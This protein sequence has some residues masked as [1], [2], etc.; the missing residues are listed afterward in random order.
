[1]MSEPVKMPVS[2]FLRRDYLH[3][4]FYIKF[5]VFVSL[6]P[7]I[8]Y[9]IPHSHQLQIQN[10]QKKEKKNTSQMR[11]RSVFKMRTSI[12]NTATTEQMGCIRF[13]FFRLY[14]IYKLV[15][16]YSLEDYSSASSMYHGTYPLMFS[17]SSIQEPSLPSLN[18][19]RILEGHLLFSHR[20]HT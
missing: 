9:L 12:L 3:I 15:F 8:N 20:F 4:F 6:V 2:H 18:S 7:Q 11:L 16:I 19:P 1:M 13:F 14:K 17:L 5:L 10:S